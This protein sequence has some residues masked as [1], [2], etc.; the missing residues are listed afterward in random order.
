MEI[1]T[2]YFNHFTAII[3]TELPPEGLDFIEG[4]AKS[5]VEKLNLNVVQTSYHEFTPQGITFLYILS[6]SHFAIHTWPENNFIHM[7]LVSCRYMKKDEFES[8]LKEVFANS[9][10][11][12]K[13][14]VITEI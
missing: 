9:K 14:V 8:T 13:K 5:I 1:S 12:I 10:N 4:L 7:D 2:P 11:Q 3:W 6:Q